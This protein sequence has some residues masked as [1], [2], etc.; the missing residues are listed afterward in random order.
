MLTRSVAEGKHRISEAIGFGE[1]RGA[2][3]Q[4]G[5]GVVGA[6][7]LSGQPVVIT[8]LSS[9][10]EVQ[11]PNL[12][13]NQIRGALS[14][15]M[16]EDKK[17]WGTLSVF[18]TNAHGW[19]EDDV[20]VL[21]TLANESVVAV[22]NAELYDTS[23][24][25]IWELSNL[26]EG[27]KAVTSTLDLDDVLEIVLGWAGKAAEAQIGCIALLDEDK[28]VLTL[29]SSYG[30]DQVTAK[31]LALEMG[32]DIC[33]EVIHERKP[34][35]E[36]MDDAQSG[37]GPLNP[38]AVLCVPILLREEPTGILFL[39]K[40]Q[41]GT[42]FTEDH[43]RLVTSLAAQAAISIDN[44][45]LFKSR[46]EVTIAALKALAK[47]V[48]ARD[49]YTAGHSDRVTQYSLVI[50][51]Q[52]NYA[53]DNP[54]AWRRLEQGGLLHDIGKIGVPDAVLSKPGKLT[55]EEFGLMKKHP[56]IGWEILHD[57][58]MLTDE[59]VIVRSHHERADGKG[60]P[61][62]KKADELPI[63]AW[64]M[65]AAD[66]L[67]AMTS[68]RPYRKGMSIEVALSEIAKGAGTHFHPAVAAAVLEAARSG[69]LTVAPS[70]SMFVDAPV[71][72]AFENPI[73][74]TLPP[75]ARKA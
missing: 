6:V 54:E 34:V 18:D 13:N 2:E 16:F 37:S 9:S 67:D 72:G 7:M 56:V 11:D 4:N 55:D 53:P 8:D 40:Y 52:M 5:Q 60:Y 49:P 64:I 10:W 65:S 48:D 45:K 24:R 70:D 57:L 59:L 15:P 35:M 61:D 20:R 43:R 44:A 36:H 74:Q 62:R 38:R 33:D 41:A 21:T 69:A 51:K 75:V 71:I 26:H 73:S 28:K 23:K 12:T 32:A 46:E 50:A 14:V 47:A 42:F 17:L 63:Y 3:I 30:T 25:M 29:S 31:R 1:V 39:A 22:K 58:K 19:T 68:D 66:A 27:L